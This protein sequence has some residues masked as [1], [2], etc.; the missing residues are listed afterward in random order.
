MAKKKKTYDDDDGRDDRYGDNGGVLFDKEQTMLLNYPSM[1]KDTRYTLPDS[2]STVK[3][4]WG[5][6]LNT[7]EIVFNSD[8]DECNLYERPCIYSYKNAESIA[9]YSSIKKVCGY[10]ASGFSEAVYNIRSEDG[11][12]FEYL[13]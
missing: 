3:A 10:R 2:V 9:W 1:K 4:N 8:I 11:I 6:V 12:E 7:S 5:Y 13:N